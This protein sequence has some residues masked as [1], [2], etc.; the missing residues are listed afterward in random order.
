LIRHIISKDWKLL[1]PLVV[2][3]AVFQF[4]LGWL[5][6]R[7]G[8]FGDD[9]TARALYPAL[10]I[11]WYVGIVAL[12]VAVV[13]QDA[14]PGISQ[15]WLIRPIERGDLLGAKLLFVTATICVPMLVMDLRRPPVLL[16]SKSFTCC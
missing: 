4:L 12:I 3:V 6:F 9:L 14:I 13:H 5:S 7:W 15:D 1:W 16:P 2:L 11:A 8:Y 10:N